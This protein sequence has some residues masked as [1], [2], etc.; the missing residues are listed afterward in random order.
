MQSLFLTVK[1]FVVTIF[2]GRLHQFAVKLLMLLSW[3][4]LNCLLTGLLACLLPGWFAC[5]VWLLVSAAL[6]LPQILSMFWFDCF[7]DREKSSNHCFFYIKPQNLIKKSLNFLIK[8]IAFKSWGVGK[9]QKGIH[10]ISSGYGKKTNIYS[11]KWKT[12]K[13]KQRKCNI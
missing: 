6:M 9:L 1:S 5:I 7:Y 10:Y 11:R 12:R 3:G 8:F 4:L 2:S 13:D